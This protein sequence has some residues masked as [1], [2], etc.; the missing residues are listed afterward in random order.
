MTLKTIKN[1]VLIIINLF[2]VFAIFFSELGSI[3]SPVSL[4]IPIYFILCLPILLL[5]N[6]FFVLYWVFLRKRYFLISLI[7]ILL[8]YKS[9]MTIF[10]IHFETQNSKISKN[11]LVIVSYNTNG[12]SNVQKHLLNKPNGVIEY[13]LTENPDIICIQE[14]F[15]RNDKDH[16]TQTDI[17]NLL[18]KYPYRCVK[19]DFEHF[20]AITGLATFS[21]YPIINNKRIKYESI[22]NASIYSD[23][24]VNKDTVRVFNNHLESNRFTGND[25]QLSQQLKYN[26]NDNNF[27]QTTESFSQKLKIAYPV[28]A[29]QADIIYEL[30]K[31]TPYKII[32]CG[33]FNDVPQSYTYTK[34]KSNL[35][36]AFVE[37][38]TGY[39]WTFNHSI[40]KLRIDY[41]LYDDNFE[42]QNFQIGTNNSSDHY[43]IKCVLKFKNP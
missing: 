27:I 8:S 14:Y 9:I 31:S 23:I 32:V 39:G 34:I 36:D 2:I 1:K 28:R 15:V 24:V 10:P 13:I 40:W 18:K 3:L 7:A 41:I 26:L 17:N 33:D 11:S 16:L 21:K 20:D 6:F 4:L 30:I 37:K 35:K 43:P 22:F 42:V 12:N 29:K 5:I 38:G 25:L 19:F